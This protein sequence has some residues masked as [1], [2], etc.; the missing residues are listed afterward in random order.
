VNVETAHKGAAQLIDLTLIA[1]VGL[2]VESMPSPSHSRLGAADLF[3]EAAD[4]L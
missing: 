2:E 4:G 3:A 1:L